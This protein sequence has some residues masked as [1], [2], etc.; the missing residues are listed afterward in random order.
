MLRSRFGVS[1]E[2]AANRL[3]ML[4]RAGSAGIP[5]FMLEVDHAGHRFRRAGAQGYPQA[6]FGGGCPKLP[7]HAAFAQPGQILVEA[8]EM[9]DG[10][11]FLCVARTL[12][13]PQGA[14]AERPRRTALLIGLRH[15]VQRRHRLRRCAAGL[16]Q[17][18]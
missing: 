13:G 9:P 2:Q 11:E 4:G 14:F 7:V 1:F 3:T 16:G 18:R 6:R 8:V 5:F 15:R 12:E 17:G 10:A